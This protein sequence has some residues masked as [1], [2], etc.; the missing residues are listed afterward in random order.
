MSWWRARQTGET[1]QGW[2]NGDQDRQVKLSKLPGLS[3]WRPRKQFCVTVVGRTWCKIEMGRPGHIWMVEVCFA[4]APR[5]GRRKEWCY[6]A[7]QQMTTFFLRTWI[8]IYF[9]TLQDMKNHNCPCHSLLND[10]DLFFQALYQA[11]LRAAATYIQQEVLR[12]EPRR[13][14]TENDNSPVI[15]LENNDSRT[16]SRRETEMTVR[17]SQPS[18]LSAANCNR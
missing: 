1:K 8:Y 9:W 6:A 11:D 7:D 5:G 14:C 4:Y 18:P 15:S 3:W 16:D 17:C 12:T 13:S 10:D 2:V